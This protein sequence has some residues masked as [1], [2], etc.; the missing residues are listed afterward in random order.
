MKKIF[1]LFILLFLLNSCGVV[2]IGGL[3]DDFNDLTDQQKAMIKSFEPNLQTDKDK[4]Y[5]ISA[6][7]LQ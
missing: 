5:V 2:K 3:S 1:T 7:K 4:I 6:L